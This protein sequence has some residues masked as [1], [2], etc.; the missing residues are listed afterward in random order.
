MS[1][2]IIDIR[3]SST[4]GNLKQDIITGLQATPKTLPTVILYDEKGLQIFDEIT[5]EDEYYLTD[6]EIDILQR[7]AGEIWRFVE[8]GAMLVELGAGYTSKKLY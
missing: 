4:L 7:Y 2:Q 3:N 8:D 6:A 1:P 5:H